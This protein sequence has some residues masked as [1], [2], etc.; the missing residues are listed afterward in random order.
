GDGTLD[1]S[2]I[3]RATLSSADPVEVSA[4]VGFGRLT[5]LVP[6]DVTVKVRAS[7]G[8]GD[9][10]AVNSITLSDQFDR[11]VFL[12]DD[13]DHGDVNGIGVHRTSVIGNGPVQIVVNAKVGFGEVRIEQVP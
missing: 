7:A 5:V 6:S 10:V 13:D 2:G 11:G 1:L 12:G 8:A 9:L 4:S 3:D